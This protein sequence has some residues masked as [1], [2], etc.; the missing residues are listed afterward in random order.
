M[1]ILRLHML[2]CVVVF[3][4]V[5]LR[6]AGSERKT[7]LRLAVRILF[8]I[9]RWSGQVEKE[10]WCVFVWTR[11]KRRS[12]GQGC[13]DRMQGMW[14]ARDRGTCFK[15]HEKL[16]CRSC[17]GSCCCSLYSSF[18]IVVRPLISRASHCSGSPST[19]KDDNEK[20]RRAS[21]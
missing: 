2:T 8:V 18:F 20:T 1:V 10:T 14:L 5:D 7:C 6:S 15:Y 21:G 16:R 3:A 11:F 9:R 13:S 12:I 17:C 4:W 19:S